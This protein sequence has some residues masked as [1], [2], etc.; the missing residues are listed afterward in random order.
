MISINNKVVNIDSFGDGTIL[1]KQD[2]PEATNESKFQE[3][4]ISWNYEN[5]RELVALIFLTRHVQELGYENI[6]LF[7][8]YVPNARQDRV[9][10][11]EDIF[12]LKYFA[13]VI[14]ALRYNK[15]YV[16]D[17]HS[18]VSI[19]Y[20]QNVVALSASSLID[21]TMTFLGDNLKVYPIQVFP[22][23]GAFERYSH[24]YNEE[25]MYGVKER[26]WKSME[27]K[28]FRIETNGLKNIQGRDVII[29][30]DICSYG[31]TF[32]HTACKLKE[33]GVK[34]IYIYCTHCE[35]NIFKGS[36]LEKD[37]L[38]KMVFTTDSI[39]TDTSHEKFFIYE[40]SLDTFKS[41]EEF[42]V[43]LNHNGI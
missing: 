19:Q 25:A 38:I 16:L 15:V 20:L 18:N 27:I 1:M 41:D 26:D 12:T 6:S 42:N 24:Q 2:L 8:P 31:G 5:E 35:D 3:M 36:L 40:L 13:E 4:K 10:N 21:S 39:L 7:M 22:D 23:K 29:I 37:D 9:K 17:V 11:N 28:T 34:D 43:V 14:N 30:D 32:Y 33:M